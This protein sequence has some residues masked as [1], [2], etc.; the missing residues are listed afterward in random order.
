MPTRGEALAEKLK[1]AR[2]AK[3]RKVAP[4]TVP[5]YSPKIAAHSAIVSRWRAGMAT[6]AGSSPPCPGCGP[7][8]WARIRHAAVRFLDEF[9][10]RAATLAW[11]SRDLFGIDSDGGLLKPESCG[12]IMRSN[13]RAITAVDD[14]KITFEDGGTFER[15]ARQSPSV[16]VWEYRRG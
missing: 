13:G 1:T 4:A 3:A 14:R 16:P 11:G 7:D 9:G 6:F 5:Q 15:G 10:D 12:A 2:A 8:Q